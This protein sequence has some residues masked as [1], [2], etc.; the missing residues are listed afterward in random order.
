MLSAL[1]NIVV[2]VVFAGMIA[3]AIYFSKTVRDMKSYY[4]ANNALPWSLTIGTL[5]ATW[6]GGVGTLG[7]VEYYALYGV[8]MWT[9]WCV[10]AHASRIPMALWVGPRM[11]IQTG[12]T[13]PDLLLK[14][15]GRPVAIIGAILMLV[16]SC[17]FGNITTSGFVG[18][19]AWDAP[20]LLTGVIVL[21][22]VI[23]ISVAAG[24]MGVAVTDMLMF[25]FLG[26]AVAITVPMQWSAMGGWEG[27]AQTLAALEQS[28]G[29]A[30][31]MTA[32]ALLDPIGGLTPLQALTYVILGLVIYADPAFYQRFSAADSQ[33]SGRRAMLI[34]ICIWITT[35]I[36]L[37]A[38][39]VLVDTLHPELAP[40]LGYVTLVL[41]TLPVILRALFV[42]ALIGSAISALDSYLLVAGTIAAYD[43][44]G[45]L[46]RK[47]SQK[48]LLRLTRIAIV[49]ISA[50]GLAIS[51]RFTVAMDIFIITGSIWAAGG[52][53]PIVGALLYK[54]RKTPAGG[55]LS[56]VGGCATY[57][58]FYFWLSVPVFED[59]LPVSFAISFLL[60]V[61]GNRIGKPVAQPDIQAS[62]V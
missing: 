30:E 24:L 15:Y 4:S 48:D 21:V 55:L 29:L 20:Y 44:Y 32:N 19:V 27:A 58:V 5:V 16:Y 37:I 7:S 8:S 34:C 22:F 18:K 42:I 38:Q 25:F 60:Y 40:G 31:G 23:V 59:P 39:G 62:V 57:I 3:I 2:A 43:I 56:M 13:V 9:I 10:T 26:V 53:I 17:Q 54:G 35:D 61:L 41:E 6:Y 47:A 52:V 46:N 50:I 12:V 14:H 28:G 1:D 49:V 45:K 51:F 36:V 11:R 33:R